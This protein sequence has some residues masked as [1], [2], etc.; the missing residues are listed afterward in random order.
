MTIHFSGDLS[1]AETLFRCTYQTNDFISTLNPTEFTTGHFW[2]RQ[3]LLF[4]NKN[5][6]NATQVR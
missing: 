1:W 5:I 4:V 2:T 3:L 6:E